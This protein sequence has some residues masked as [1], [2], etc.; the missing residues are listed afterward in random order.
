MTVQQ[1]S[2]RMASETA[3]VGVICIDESFINRMQHAADQASIEL[4]SRAGGASWADLIL[5][6]DCSGVMQSLGC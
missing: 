4:Q 6:C 2:L 1:V 3:V 5:A